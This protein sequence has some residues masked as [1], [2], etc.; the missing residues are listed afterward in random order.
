MNK[1]L[2]RVDCQQKILASQRST[3]E[4]GEFTPFSQSHASRTSCDHWGLFRDVDRGCG[5]T[6]LMK[7]WDM[8]VT[9]KKTGGTGGFLRQ[10]NYNFY[11]WGFSKQVS[12]TRFHDLV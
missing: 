5:E 9:R 10:P 11:F 7:C 6:F 8:F 12:L 2:I 4:L 1:H 3:H